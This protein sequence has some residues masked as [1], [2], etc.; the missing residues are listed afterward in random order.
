LTTEGVTYVVS[1]K[2]KEL[3]NRRPH[4]RIIDSYETEFLESG[5]LMPKAQDYVSLGLMMYMAA[6]A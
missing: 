5:D 1:E 4:R 3:D 6:E 2:E